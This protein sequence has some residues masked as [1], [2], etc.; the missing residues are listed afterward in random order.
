MEQRLEAPPP[1]RPGCTHHARYLNAG[2]L[3]GTARAVSA[4]YASLQTGP[5]EDDQALLTEL[6]LRQPRSSR[7]LV[8]DSRF[9]LFGNNAHCNLHKGL[10]FEEACVFEYT[11]G[12]SATGK[13]PGFV[14]RNDTAPQAAPAF[15]HFPGKFDACYWHLRGF[16]EP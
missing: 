1:G 10:P 9:E 12:A 2:A 13:R 11:T 3:A 7:R 16:V 5:R 15:I 6:Y 14:L 4:L 8:L